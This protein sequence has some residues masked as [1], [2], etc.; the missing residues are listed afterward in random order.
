[1]LPPTDRWGNS[2]R[3]WNTIPM[4]RVCGARSV[5]SSP[6]RK[7][8]PSVGVSRPALIRRSVVFPQPEG[9]RNEISLPAGSSRSTPATAVTSPKRLT[10]PWSFSPPRASTPSPSPGLGQ[11]HLGPLLVD[12][13]LPDVVHLVLRPER[14]LAPRPTPRHV[15][16]VGEVHRLLLGRRRGAEGARELGTT[17]TAKKETM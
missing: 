17:P 16:L 12:P 6:S 5:M 3:V 7:T 10:R 2:A 14:H 9:P 8:P 1:M 11:D 15:L 4:S 13:V